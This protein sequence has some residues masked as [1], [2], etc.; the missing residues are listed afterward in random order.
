MLRSLRKW[1]LCIAYISAF[2]IYVWTI[3]SGKF[4]SPGGLIL[5]LSM[6]GYVIWFSLANFKRR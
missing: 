5:L 4:E 3:E 6:L 1:T 2:F